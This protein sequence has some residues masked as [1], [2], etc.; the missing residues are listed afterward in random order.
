MVVSSLVWFA[1]LRL[2]LA[3]FSDGLL[4]PS[5]TCGDSS[6]ALPTQLMLPALEDRTLAAAW[7]STTSFV[8]RGSLINVTIESFVHRGR[9]P[10][11]KYCTNS[12][13][14]GSLTDDG[15]GSGLRLSFDPKDQRRGNTLLRVS[16]V[17]LG[18][19]MLTLR[20]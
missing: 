6:P 19:L 5:G 15:T 7:P 10:D 16:L 18:A 20:P 2:K 3:V 11:S 12:T 9:R 13:G 17:L 14:A 4:W 1:L 8:L